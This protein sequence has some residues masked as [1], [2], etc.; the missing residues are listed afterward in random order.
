VVIH[1]LI[2]SLFGIS[3]CGYRFP[4]G[5]DIPGGLASV[6]IPLF[7]NLT[8]EIGLENIITNDLTNEFIVRRKKS[9]STDDAAADGRLEGKIVS[10]N[11][12][13]ITQTVSGGSV[14]REVVVAVNVRLLDK[15]GQVVWLAQNVSARENYDVGSNSTTAD[16]NRQEAIE[17]LSVRLAEKIFNRLVEDF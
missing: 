10:V 4:G 5:G 13:T 9:L 6:S 1:I 14:E 15:D 3:G 8:N 17:A 2:I 12:R 16:A 7:T 11:T